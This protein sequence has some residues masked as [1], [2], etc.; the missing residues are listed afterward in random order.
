M[1]GERALR[2]VDVIAITYIQDDTVPGIG[3]VK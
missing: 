1:A 2:K 3:Q